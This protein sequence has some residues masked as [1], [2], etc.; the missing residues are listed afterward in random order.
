MPNLNKV[1]LMGNLT[2]DP[3]LRYTPSN[4]AVVK[5]GLAVN[6]RWRNQN[7]E[8]QEETTFVDCTAFGRTGEV[9]NQ[10]LKK[11]RPVF[12][13]GRLHLNQWEDQQGQ[14]R[15]KLEVIVEGFQFIDSRQGGEG[16]GGG[17]YGGGEGYAQ[18]GG[19]NRSAGPG[20]GPAPAG[21]S[22]APPGPPHQ[23]VEEDDI[24]F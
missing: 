6:R 18:Q 7:G 14:K 5:L 13:E 23:A 21:R 4:T 24:P 10:Y 3:E 9:L 2:R 16:D 19:G 12:I 17:G 1:M 22:S 8:Q 20:R 11:G 15:S